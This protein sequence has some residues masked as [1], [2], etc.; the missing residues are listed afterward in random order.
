LDSKASNNY[1]PVQRPCLVPPVG[2]GRHLRLAQRR[3]LRLERR[4]RLRSGAGL[5]ARCLRL[6]LLQQNQRLEQQHLRS[7]QRR[8]SERRRL[9]SERRH[10]RSERRHQRSERR[11]RRLAC[12]SQ[13]GVK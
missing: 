10:Q 11:H 4:R 12:Q 5:A 8:R 2:S 13:R 7:E 3:R 1:K 9:R 6:V